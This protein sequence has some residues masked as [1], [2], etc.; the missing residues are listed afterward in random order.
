MMAC[1]VEAEVIRLTDLALSASSRSDALYLLSKE[2]S[3]DGAL[4]KLVQSDPLDIAKLV[5][6]SPHPTWVLVHQGIAKVFG[7][8][9]AT[10]GV[11]L[12][13]LIGQIP[14]PITQEESLQQSKRLSAT[15]FS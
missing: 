10:L 1:L 4:R 6:I 11:I 3:Q 7:A 5:T 14:S 15:L 2:I 12:R 8:D 13:W 9:S